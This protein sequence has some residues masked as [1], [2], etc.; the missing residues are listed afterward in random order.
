MEETQAHHARIQEMLHVDDPDVAAANLRFLMDVG[1]IEDPVVRAG[2]DI[3]LE[4]R[5]PGQGAAMGGAGRNMR[6][7][8]PIPELSAQLQEALFETDL[9][10]GYTPADYTQFGP[11]TQYCA[12][13]FLNAKYSELVMVV[14][15]TPR[16]LL[17]WLEAVFAPQDWRMQA[18]VTEQER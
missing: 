7:Q 13:R 10:I 6:I 5:M 17:D 16:W 14:N 4:R 9:C 1:L 8:T 3:Y 18:G 12:Q 2:G 11:L 15:R